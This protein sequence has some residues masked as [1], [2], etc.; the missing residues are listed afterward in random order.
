MS[1]KE[2]EKKKTNKKELVDT[3]KREDT[4]LRD[5]DQMCYT[6]SLCAIENKKKVTGK[7]EKKE[8]L[9]LKQFFR[10]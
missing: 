4:S 5:S 6:Q 10:R 2:E 1:K 3:I 9:V 8:I 7:G